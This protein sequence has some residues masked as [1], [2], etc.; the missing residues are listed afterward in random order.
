MGGKR[1]VLV[2]QAFVN[3]YFPHEDPIGRLAVGDWASPAPAEIV[4]VVGDIRHD[5]LTS[6]P[7]PTFYLS[8][9]QSPGFTP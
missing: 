6:E 1:T 2:N 7:R 5:A 9:A 8:Q 4:G 3:R